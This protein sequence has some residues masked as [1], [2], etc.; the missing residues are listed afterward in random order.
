MSKKSLKSQ[1]A[2]LRHELAAAKALDPDT[3]DL[4]DALAADIDDALGKREPGHASLRERVEAAT[5]K[6]ESAHP[7]F[8][9]ILGDITDTLAKLGF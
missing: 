6:F 9:S 2:A 3:R 8:A 4:L 7:R 5:L 1:L